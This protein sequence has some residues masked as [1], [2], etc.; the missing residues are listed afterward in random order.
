ME[1]YAAMD[2]VHL[3][4]DEGYKSAADGVTLIHMG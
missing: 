1:D 3:P 2:A 4:A